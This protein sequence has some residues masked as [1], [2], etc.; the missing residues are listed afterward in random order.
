MTWA[1]PCEGAFGLLL[2]LCTGANV[3]VDEDASVIP[4]ESYCGSYFQS[5]ILTVKLVLASL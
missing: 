5:P 1:W 2:V 3:D 4:N